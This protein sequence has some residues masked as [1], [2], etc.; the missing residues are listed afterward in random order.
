MAETRLSLSGLVTGVVDAN[1]AANDNGALVLTD[2]VGGIIVG[3]KED[4]CDART[5]GS[6]SG[7]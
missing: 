2:G 3:G 5:A 1:G 7:W 6:S 4:I